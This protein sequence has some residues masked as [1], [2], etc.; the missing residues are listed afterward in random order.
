[1][2]VV[3]DVEELIPITLEGV[4]TYK[5]ENVCYICNKEIT[6]HAKYYP[7]VI[8]GVSS[9]LCYKCYETKFLNKNYIIKVY[10]NILDTNYDLIYFNFVRDMSVTELNLNNISITDVRLTNCFNIYKYTFFKKL[11]T[12]LQKELIT[13]NWF[14][15][16]E[17]KLIRTAPFTCEMCNKK[18]SSDNYDLINKNNIYYKVCN[19]CKTQPL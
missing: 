1:M 10:I 16:V 7:I 15:V 8:N 4:K 18:L 3:K 5:K 11:L 19:N 6:A 17:L 12:N 14:G 9:R 13:K 2:S